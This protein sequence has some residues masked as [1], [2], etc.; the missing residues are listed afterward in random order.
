MALVIA[1]EGLPFAM[2]FRKRGS[3]SVRCE[4]EGNGIDCES[5]QLFQFASRISVI[6]AGIVSRVRYIRSYSN[7]Y[8][9]WLWFDWRQCRRPRQR[10]RA[11]TR[12][13][14]L[15]RRRRWRTRT[16]TNS[17]SQTKSD[18]NLTV[19]GRTRGM[20][21][22]STG[23]VAFYAALF[24]STCL[25]RLSIRYL[26]SWFWRSLPR[27]FWCGSRPIA[28]PFSDAQADMFF[29]R[30]RG[31]S[32]IDY[33]QLKLTQPPFLNLHTRPDTHFSRYFSTAP[34]RS[35][36]D[37][38]ILIAIP[39]LF[40]SSLLLLLTPFSQLTRNCFCFDTSFSR[41]SRIFTRFSHSLR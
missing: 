12:P 19:V 14:Y 28:R 38:T 25:G 13:R 8:H 15:T 34:S 1:S 16:T 32:L 35:S 24:A 26:I 27:A 11:A 37:P 22:W 2:E 30:V 36:P 10:R 6:T 9:Y 40:N 4:W 17:S 5:R 29:V 21:N 39:F 3:I 41:L 7:N 18:A 23:W 33:F 20:T 31:P